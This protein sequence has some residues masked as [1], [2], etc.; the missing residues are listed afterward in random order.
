M[1]ATDTIFAL[2]TPPGKSGV[3]VVRVSGAAVASVASS[4]GIALPAPRL[5][6]LCTLRSQRLALDR[7]LV[8]YFPAPHSF[9]GEDILEFHV[10]GGRAVVA[11]LLRALAAV[12]GLRPAEAG[13]FT[14]RA[15]FNGK[16]DL[17]AAEGLADLIDAETE[18]QRKQAVR[19]MQGEAAAF[20]DAL[21]SGI[22]Q[23]LALMEAYIDFPDEEIP[24]TVLTETHTDVRKL[25]GLIHAQLNDN[26]A[27]ERVRD[28]VKI[29]IIG[30]PNAG[31][32]SLLNSLAKRDVAIV[33]ETAGTTRDV[34]EVH[35]DIAGYAVSLADTAGIREAEDKVEQEGVR[36]SL[37]RAEEADVRLVVVDAGAMPPPAEIE[38]LAGEQGM[39]V[40]TKTDLHT[41]SPLSILP[42]AIAV[43]TVTGAGMEALLAALS[44]KVELLSAYESSFISRARHRHH[45]GQAYDHLLAYLAVENQGLEIACEEL[46]RAA[47][48]IGR[49]TGLIDPDE[50]LGFIFS[51]FCIGK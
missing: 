39:V 2:S 10:H 14:R 47:L 4:L 7:A 25:L 16:L 49:I 33:S 15:F 45:L 50:V 19:F 18:A 17:T 27:A 11:T 6:T 23:A 22:V 31:K 44:A 13:E 9:S 48:E 21:R 30:P 8:L 29:T 41:P 1:S 46:R 5:A 24:E 42:G 32:S 40:I 20:Y 28:G 34:I 51:R 38:K 37:V 43:S 3:A 12:D 36:R 26:R 35:L